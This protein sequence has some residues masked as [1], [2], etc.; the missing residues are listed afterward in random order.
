L[1]RREGDVR[2]LDGGKTPAR[3]PT[4]QPSHSK[5]KRGHKRKA[6]QPPERK[7]R[8][9]LSEI[10]KKS[11]GKLDED[12]VILSGELEKKGIEVLYSSSEKIIR[13]IDSSEPPKILSDLLFSDIPALIAKPKTHEQVVDCVKLCRKKDIPLVVRGAASSAFGGVLP[14]N[15]GVVLDFGELAG[16]LSIDV[17]KL[18]AKALAGTRW[19]DISLELRKRDLALKTS[20]SSIF[21]TLG[22]WLSTGGLGINS[23]LYG[24]IAKHVK[25]I[26]V[27]LPDGSEKYLV[28]EDRLF[29]LMMGSEGQLG[30]ITEV[31]LSV[32]KAPRHRRAILI[33]TSNDAMAFKLISSIIGGNPSITHIMFF[34]ELRIKELNHLTPIP[35]DPLHE[36]PAILVE[37]ESDQFSDLRLEMPQ[38]I[39]TSEAPIFM[40]NLLWGDRYFPMRGRMRG[41]GLLGAEVVLPINAVPAYLSKVRNLGKLFGLEIASESH[42]ISKKEALVL[43]FFL[44]DQRRM[45]MYT[46]HAVLSLLM[47]RIATELKGRPYAIGI[48]NQPFSSF[49]VPKDRM[50]ILKK[51]NEEL[52]PGDRFNPGKFLSRTGKLTGPIAIFLRERL[53]LFA[54][55]SLLA[56]ASLTGRISR[57]FFSERSK[58]DVSNLD[59]S[60]LACARCGACIN[61]CPA[62]LV[63]G[64]ETVTGRGKLLLYRQM[65]AGIPLDDDDAKEIFLC[66]KCHACEEVCQTGLPLLSAYEELE[67]KLEEMYG[68]PKN[69]IDN[70][71]AE[72]E[73]SPEYEKM[74][75]D[76][77]IS[78][79]AAVKEVDTDAV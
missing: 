58:K 30:A 71:V 48:W 76:G 54:L 31:I 60:A 34:D 66:M 4:D 27:V 14:P 56:A 78:P 8:Q 75:Y 15:G 25:K 12:L 22:G 2:K 16:A 55:G 18:E 37:M 74:L 79:D 40:A 59:I 44:T 49:V 41:P 52:D 35:G 6:G 23:Y 64:R 77:T 5:L 29:D 39:S 32:R 24:H 69:L 42:I 38:E 72:V 53:T 50:T 3:K 19:T 47:T 10:E 65:M 1:E 62:Y 7:I 70:F 21:S 43:S 26:R 61:V 67:D 46:I 20:P 17:E 9:R 73:S 51:T 68:K 28:P 13:S 63:T 57:R 11:L 33:Q 36:S 45:L